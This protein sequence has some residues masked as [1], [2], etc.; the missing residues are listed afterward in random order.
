[1]SNSNKPFALGLNGHARACD[2]RSC[3]S[4]RLK[5]YKKWFKTASMVPEMPDATKTVF[6]RPHWRKQKN[7]L[8]RMPKFKKAL[9]NTFGG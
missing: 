7:H 6:V 3:V 8:K 1:M 2:C 5:M 9:F 4:D